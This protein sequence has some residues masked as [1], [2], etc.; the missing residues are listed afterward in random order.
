MKETVSQIFLIRTALKFSREFQSEVQ[1]C[2]NGVG[3][4]VQN[5]L[6]NLYTNFVLTSAESLFEF[7]CIGTSTGT[8]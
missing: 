2:Y 6:E 4:K 5:S 8:T 1:V 7:Y 3:R